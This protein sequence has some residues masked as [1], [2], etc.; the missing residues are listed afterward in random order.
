[1]SG[2]HVSESQ[3]QGPGCQGPVS[4]N[5]ESRVS[6]LRVP[7][8]RSQVLILDYVTFN[9]ICQNLSALKQFLSLNFLETN[10]GGTCS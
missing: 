5:P 6:G 3:F 7:D 2:S 1:M 9:I 4:Q 8:P 10:N